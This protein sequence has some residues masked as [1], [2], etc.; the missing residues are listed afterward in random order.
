MRIKTPLLSHELEGSVY[1]A[2]PAANGEAGRNPFDSLVALYLVA[3]DPVSGVLVKLAGEGGLDE[4][5]L[6]VSTSFKNAPQVPFEE[7]TLNLFGGQRG[8]LTTPARCGA[9]ATSA[10]FTPWSGPEEVRLPLRPRTS[11]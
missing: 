8:S 6:Q 7:L 1:L 4:R 9:Y 10:I 3:E 5:T 11:R 2:S